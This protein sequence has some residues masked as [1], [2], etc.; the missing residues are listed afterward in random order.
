MIDIT[1]RKAA[2]TALADAKDFSEN[3]LENS[4]VPCFVL[5]TDHRVI[6]WTRACEELTGMRAED[7]VGTDRHWQA[8][9]DHRRPSLADLIIDGNLEGTLDLYDRFAN[10]LLIPEGLQAE[11][12][13]P[14]IGG[15]SRYLFF[16]AAPIRDRKGRPVS[17]APKR[18]NS[19]AARR[20][21]TS[22]TR[23]IGTPC[24]NASPPPKSTTQKG[25]ISKKGYCA[26]TGR[27]SMS[28]PVPPRS[29]TAANGPCRRCCGT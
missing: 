18:P 13:F 15:R 29:F 10:S 7:V 6:L 8:F 27:W 19:F 14:A 3:L 2:E 12:W 26:S 11:A 1:P 5:N 17:S 20:S 22:S 25:P 23:T 9:Y 28:R 4:A 24:R 16:E 21:S